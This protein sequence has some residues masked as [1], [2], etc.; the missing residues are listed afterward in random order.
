MKNVN[1][2]LV[3][4]MLVAQLCLTLCSPMDWGPLCMEFS[5]QEYWSGLLFPPLVDLPNQGIKSE[6]PA[7]QTYYLPIEPPGKPLVSLGRDGIQ[8][9][10]LPSCV[11]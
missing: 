4:L 6:S 8:A 10:Q 9:L 2:F 5:R 3:L 7:L 11:M 1:N